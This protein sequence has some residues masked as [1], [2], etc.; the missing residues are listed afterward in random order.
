M[1]H[2]FIIKQIVSTTY[3]CIATLIFIASTIVFGDDTQRVYENN[4]N[5]LLILMQNVRYPIVS[6]MIFRG[7]ILWLMT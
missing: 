5:L 2:I 1:P 3:W 4:Y 6:I 7:L